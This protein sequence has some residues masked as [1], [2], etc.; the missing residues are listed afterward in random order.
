[1]AQ[2]SRKSTTLFVRSYCRRRPPFSTRFY[3]KN[4]GEIDESSRHR[5]TLWRLHT[6]VTIAAAPRIVTT[7]QPSA[8]VELTPTRAAIGALSMTGY[9]GDREES[10]ARLKSMHQMM[11]AEQL[12]DASPI[13]D[14]D[15]WTIYRLASAADFWLIIR[16]SETSDQVGIYFYARYDKSPLDESADVAT[17]D[18]QETLQVLVDDDYLQHL[19]AGEQRRQGGAVLGRLLAARLRW[20]GAHHALRRRAPRLNRVW[21]PC[22]LPEAMRYASFLVGGR[23]RRRQRTTTCRS[24]IAHD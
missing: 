13:V 14:D 6:I 19:M 16:L 2:I 4:D 21:H 1:M 15:G 8:V 22:R 11:R 12:V 18:M 7:T 3:W 24:N 23:R 17:P 10:D 20:G 5:S 9:D